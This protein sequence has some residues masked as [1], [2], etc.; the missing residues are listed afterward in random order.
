MLR[1][2]HQ[3]QQKQ[4]QRPP[5]QPKELTKSCGGRVNGRRSA[6]WLAPMGSIAAYATISIFM[7]GA[8][9]PATAALDRFG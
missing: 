5:P 9:S 7:P 6:Y 1:A 3:Q 8:T 2:W 4:H